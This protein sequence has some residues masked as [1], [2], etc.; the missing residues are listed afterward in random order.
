MQ[1]C[2]VCRVEFESRKYG[3]V[4]CSRKCRQRRD[5]VDN[6]VVRIAAVLAHQ[7]APES[8][9]ETLQRKRDAWDAL[10]ADPVRYRAYLDVRTG[11]DAIWRRLRQKYGMSQEQYEALHEAQGGLCS[12]CGKP[13]DP[14]GTI[15]RL[16]VD[17]DHASNR[18]RALLCDAC[19]R[20]L[21][22]FL[23]DPALLEAAAQYLRS[24]HE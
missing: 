4:Y 12:I 16:V 2:P 10:R 1:V 23:D 8:R 20:G 7:N 22:F 24:H 14:A 19:N 15:T 21:G 11:P 13:Q 18:V 5:Y 9:E 17:H 3:T 6:R